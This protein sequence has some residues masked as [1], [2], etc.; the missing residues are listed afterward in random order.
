MRSGKGEMGHTADIAG[1]LVGI[2]GTMAGFSFRMHMRRSAGFHVR[3]D[4]EC[5]VVMMMWK[6]A[7]HQHPQADKQ[8]AICIYTM[9][10]SLSLTGAKVKRNT[11]KNNVLYADW[12]LNRFLANVSEKLF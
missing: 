2:T 8:Q 9:F 4:T 5:F 1:M 6:N 7:Y 11:E 10:H 12:N 3:M